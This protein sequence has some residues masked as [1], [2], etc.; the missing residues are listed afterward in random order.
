MKITREIKEAADIISHLSSYGS[1][2]T[3]EGVSYPGGSHKQFIQRAQRWLNKYH[4]EIN[5]M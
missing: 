1:I 5:Q 2:H 4:K 3:V